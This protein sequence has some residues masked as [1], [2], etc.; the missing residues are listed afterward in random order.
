MKLS[1]EYIRGLVDGEGCFTFYTSQTIRNGRV[2]KIR[3]PA[4][5]ISMHERDRALVEAVRD[6]LGVNNRV[7]NFRSPRYGG[8][9]RGNKV[10]LVVRKFSS[11]KNVIVPFFYKKL[12]G[13]KGL[14]FINWLE[15]IGSDPM[16]PD[17][18]KLLYRLHSSGYFEKNPKF[19]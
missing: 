14:Q 16:V 1:N 12:K 6:S 7:Y 3:I 2:V 10:V 9:L 8:S 4:F 5:A 19:V 11:L 15:K 17:I 13:N 18:Y